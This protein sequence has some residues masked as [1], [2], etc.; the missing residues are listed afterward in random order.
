MNLGRVLKYRFEGFLMIS[1]LPGRLFQ[2][3]LRAAAQSKC[4]LKW[5][6]AL[7]SF[8]FV[9]TALRGANPRF[10]EFMGREH[11]I[12]KILGFLI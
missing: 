5:C 3:F 12:S 6:E 7:S 11:Q 9:Q 1:G 4:L 8:S 10:Y 2:T